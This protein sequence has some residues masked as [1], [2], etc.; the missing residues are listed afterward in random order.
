MNVSIVLLGSSSLVTGS[1]IELETQVPYD[2]RKER[3][4]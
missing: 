2:Q 3:E 1:D 4:I